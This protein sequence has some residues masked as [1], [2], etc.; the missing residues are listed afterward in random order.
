MKRYYFYIASFMGILLWGPENSMA[1]Q[2]ALHGQFSLWTVMSNQDEWRNNMGIRYIPEWTMEQYLSDEMFLDTEVT[3]NGFAAFDSQGEPHEDTDLDW[4]R[5]K[6]RFATNQTETQIGLQKL[7][8]GPA[9]LLRSL[10]WFD[11]V[12]PRDPL[13]LTDGVYALRFRYNALNNANLWLWGLYGNDKPKGYEL[14]PSVKEVPEFGGRFQ[15]PLWTGEFAFSA[16]TREVNG[17]P[18]KIGNFRENRI[19]LDGRWEKTIGM[20]F[21]TVLQQQQ[22][23]KLPY[24]WRKFATFGADYTFGIGNGLYVVAE[25]FMNVSSEE[26][27]A[28]DEDHYNSA[29]SLNY[30][31]GFFDSVTTIAYYS[32]DLG[33]ASLFGTWQ[34]G[35]DNY[36]LNF[37]LFNYP[38]YD[39]VD[40]DVRQSPFS[41]YGGQIMI[42][43][44]H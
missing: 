42:V 37:A 16:H 35:F 43:F 27:F 15:Y 7:N 19:A 38:R 14:L 39:V 23:D 24:E 22:S 9:Q 36:S 6:L 41:G 20:W 21:E 13:A 31:I 25:H 18:F 4:Y 33:K 32:W 2:N 29:L 28:W 10:Q 3:L 44:F 34:R 8:F 17:S 40:A 11:Q 5:L 30:P 26:A 12:D 1:L